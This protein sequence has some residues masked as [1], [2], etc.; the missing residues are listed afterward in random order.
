[1]EELFSN[2]TPVFNQF[3]AKFYNDNGGLTEDDTFAFRLVTYYISKSDAEGECIDWIL[4]YLTQ[5]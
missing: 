2:N 5:K 1:M 3:L 4:Q